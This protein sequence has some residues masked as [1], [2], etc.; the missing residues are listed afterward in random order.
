MKI[1]QVRII[2]DQ[3]VLEL[4]S[5]V[6]T[7]ELSFSSRDRHYPH[8]RGTVSVVQVHSREAIVVVNRRRGVP[9][10]HPALRDQ[11]TSGADHVPTQK[12]SAGSQKFVGYLPDEA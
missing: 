7:D 3:L 1:Q 12:C 9:R 8:D 6:R 5:A 10:F 4:S 11:R 2:L